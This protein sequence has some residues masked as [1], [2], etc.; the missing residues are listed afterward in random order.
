MA[1][2]KD[3]IKTGALSDLIR[4]K[5]KE[6]VYF[7]CVG[8]PVEFYAYWNNGKVESLAKEKQHPKAI[9]RFRMNVAVKSDKGVLEM[10]ILENGATVYNLLASYNREY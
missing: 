9:F 10:K 4:L 3:D 6:H 8:D 5:D 7:I 1:K 2:F